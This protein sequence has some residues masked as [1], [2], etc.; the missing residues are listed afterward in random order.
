[1]R[2]LNFVRVHGPEYATGIGREIGHALRT[3]GHDVADFNW[4]VSRPNIPVVMTRMERGLTWLLSHDDPMI[5]TSFPDI[6]GWKAFWTTYHAVLEKHDLTEIRSFNHYTDDPYR[7]LSRMILT[8]PNARWG[9]NDRRFVS[10]MK[11]LRSSDPARGLRSSFIAFPAG[12]PDPEQEIVPFRD[13]EIEVLFVGNCD[14]QV[15]IEELVHSFFPDHPDVLGHVVDGLALMDDGITALDA[16]LRVL[17]GLEKYSIRYINSVRHVIE[18]YAKISQ[19][20]RV[21]EAL[22]DHPVTVLGRIDESAL[23]FSNKFTFLGNRPYAE[24]IALTHRAKIVVNPRACFPNGAHEPVLL[25]FASGAGVLTNRSTLFDDDPLGLK[26]ATA[27]FSY[28]GSDAGD[29]LADL[30]SRL[31]KGRIDQRESVAGYART[32]TWTRR[33]E[34][35]PWAVAKPA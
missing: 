27:T 3:L 26:N 22:K 4:P 16:T 11:L 13:R 17:G 15:S 29:A 24:C 19:R 30:R 21:L 5:V 31:D 25:G 33:F 20:I 1:M 9:L 18:L 14:P 8:G 6:Y 2:I 12:G 23:G 7:N 32:H 28:D 34:T 10:T 35:L